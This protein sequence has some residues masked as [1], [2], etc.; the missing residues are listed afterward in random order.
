MLQ[1]YAEN[2]DV[3]VSL[4]QARQKLDTF[5]RKTMNRNVLTRLRSRSPFHPFLVI[6]ALALMLTALLSV[7][8]ITIMVAPLLSRDIA[9]MISQLDSATSLP[10]PIAV[11]MLAGGALLFAFGAHMAALV[12]GRNAPLLT[13]EARIHQRLVS[14]VKRLEAQ[15]AVS[16]RLTP[17]PP[18]PRVHAS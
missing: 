3:T 8:A 12:A 16:A 7:G 17:R 1:P 18:R 9:I 10:L 5:E 2:Q 13:Q 6:R 15:R 14:D 11:G 4:A